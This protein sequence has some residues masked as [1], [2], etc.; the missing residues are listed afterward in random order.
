MDLQLMSI[1]NS[2]LANVLMSD[3]NMSPFVYSVYSS[4]PPTSR[5][6]VSVPCA[7][8]W[9]FGKSSSFNVP[10]Y[11][12]LCHAVLE[13]N[14]TV[15]TAAATPCDNYGNMVIKRATMSSHSREVIAL[16]TMGN[17]VRLSDKDP[18]SYDRINTISNGLTTF[19]ISTTPYKLLVPLNFSVFDNPASY[20]DTSFIE[21]LELNIELSP[22][23]SLFNQTTITFNAP[24]SKVHFYFLNM[25]ESDLRSLQNAQYSVEKPLSLLTKSFFKDTSYVSAT[26]E[27]AGL[28]MKS[29]TVSCPNLISRTIIGVRLSTG[30]K[31]GTYISI[32]NVVIKS[33]GRVLYEY[34]DVNEN[35]LENAL[36]YDRGAKTNDTK[37]FVHN[38]GLLANQSQFGGGV[39]GKGSSNLTIEVSFTATAALHTIDIE[40]EY[41]SIV[42][43][44]GGSGKISQSIS[45]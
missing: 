17:L 33:S 24:A 21:Q 30:A 41:Y 1:T 14:F 38:W 43:V 44:S 9:D 36:F 40:H 18:D 39:S 28:V 31:L 2:P 3:S 7:S 35:G 45:L 12:L 6:K 13:I 10:R 26:N 19:P 20:L 15:A 27:T 34:N 29:L 22:L 4:L 25:S 37:L 5:Q 23:A 42:S 32:S 8:S 11:G 16:E